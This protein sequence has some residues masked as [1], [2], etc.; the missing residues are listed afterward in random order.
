MYLIPAFTDFYDDTSANPRGD[1]KFYQSDTVKTTLNRDF[2]AGGY[3][4]NYLPFVEGIV[5]RFR[6]HKRIFAWE[7][8]NE[9]K[10]QQIVG[11]RQD[12]LPELFI[13]FAQA[14]SNRIR[15]LDPSHLITT[16]IIST[17][18]LGCNAEQAERLY[19][20]P[21]LNFVTVHSYDDQNED[22]SSVAQKVG[23]PLIVEEAGFTGG[24]RAQKTRDD[25]DKWFGRNARGYMQW[26]FMATP[27]DNGDG[28]RESGMDH[29][30]HNGDWQ[31][32]VDFY[33][34]RAARLG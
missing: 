5:Q 13:Q 14:V 19:R 25:M 27:N 21:N 6:A 20:L 17:R 28:N 24:D 22:D 4:E 34:D 26:G 18:V 12:F 2:F 31:R 30:F 10:A 9:L 16:G 7:L 29:A 33:R 1:E 15:Q 23:K 32:Y 11:G 8:G 3:R